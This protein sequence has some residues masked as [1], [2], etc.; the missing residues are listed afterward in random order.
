MLKEGKRMR[1]GR[2][3]EERKERRRYLHNHKQHLRT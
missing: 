3:D 2:E 1:G